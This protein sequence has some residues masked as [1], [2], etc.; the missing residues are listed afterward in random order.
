MRLIT[1]I[2]INLAVIHDTTDYGKGH[3]EY[4]SKS[5]QSSAADHGTSGSPQT[6]RTHCRAHADQVAQL[7]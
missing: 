3:N 4:F 7:R 6:S 1:K 2:D 5:L